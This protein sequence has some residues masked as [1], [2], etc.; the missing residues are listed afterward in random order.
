MFP[1]GRRRISLELYAKIPE[2]K[3]HNFESA[4]LD[5]IAESPLLSEKYRKEEYCLGEV[6][7]EILAHPLADY[8]RT[9]FQNGDIRAFHSEVI[10]RKV[11]KGI[12]GNNAA[13]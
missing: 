1:G 10:S 12:E 11:R 2:Q 3:R 4:L 8:C 6:E 5:R 9:L 7:P 13:L